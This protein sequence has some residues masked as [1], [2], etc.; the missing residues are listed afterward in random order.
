M[1][2]IKLRPE[3][4]FTLADLKPYP[5]WVNWEE[6]LKS[7]SEKMIKPPLNS[8]TAGLA[9]VTNPKDWS[10]YKEAAKTSD[11][12]GI[13]LGQCIGD[14][15]VFGIDLDHCYRGHRL[16]RHAIDILERFNTYTEVSPSH[17]GLHCLFVMTLAAAR[18][19]KKM[20]G[21]SRLTMHVEGEE[22]ALDV[23]ARYYTVT[24]DRLEDHPKF[25][26]V[27]E[28]ADVQWLIETYGGKK[29]SPL[30]ERD[31]SDSGYG[32]RTMMSM[33]SHGMTFDQAVAEMRKNS[34]RAAAWAKRV[35][36]RQLERAWEAASRRVEKPAA[37]SVERSTREKWVP[38]II[39]AAQLQT[40]KF[41][42]LK[43]IVPKYIVA[44]L[45]II[46]GPPKIK[47]SFL[48]F[49]I[50]VA[51]ATGGEFFGSKCKQGDVLF[52]ALEDNGRR[53]KRRMRDQLGGKPWPERLHLVTEWPRADEGGLEAIYD[54]VK[55][56]PDCRLI[57][58]DVLQLFRP[59]TKRTESAYEGDY[60]ALK[61]LQ[62][63][64]LEKHI[65]VAV[66]HH[67]RKMGSDDP[68]DQVSGTHGITGV[69]DTT[70]V[71]SAM[72]SGARLYGRGRDLVEDIDKALEFDEMGCKWVIVGDTD[73]V[74]KSDTRKRILQALKERPM[75]PV[76][77][78]D[79]TGMKRTTA[80]V[81]LMRM[82][83]AGD[84]TKKG[85]KYC[86]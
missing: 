69:A 59:H 25:L 8:R 34:D 42:A 31:E 58:I 23:D 12:I 26:R 48:M 2:I 41:P 60:N 52:I 65:G 37:R 53:L 7:E 33:A 47:K 45:T 50:G 17:Q 54:W 36:Q 74:K 83:H 86:L 44:G 9:S 21:K 81:M 84:V 73:E 19:V 40:M 77:V 20:L 11:K 63:L 72:G 51:V 68:F 75:S 1:T 43:Q 24:E 82:L 35:D 62:I 27:V 30:S 70:L 78:A 16:Y 6:R 79:V 67:N 80:R 29:K 3:A 38:N 4:G 55:A 46:A 22:V 15:Y 64:G 66:S 57:L 32:F 56:H 85:E 14:K 61:G 76:E 5:L 13:I 28:I 49:N 10:T 71:M 39:T 18:V